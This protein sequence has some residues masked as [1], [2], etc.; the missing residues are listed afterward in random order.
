MAGE[1]LLSGERDTEDIVFGTLTR[2]A[3]QKMNARI[4]VER[5]AKIEPWYLE[6]F[7]FNRSLI[8]KVAHAI[9]DFNP[10]YLD[11]EYARQ[12]PFGTII[13]PPGVLMW[14]EQTNA[15][16]DGFPGLHALWREVT[17]EWKLPVKLGDTFTGK[18]VL[19][20]VA[21]VESELSGVAATQDYINI[22]TNQDGEEIGQVHTS[23]H[24][25]ERPTS[26]ARGKKKKK[27]ELARYR[28]ED[29][30][31]I[32]QDYQKEIRRGSTP[33][34]W[35]EVEAGEEIPFVV[36]GPTSRAQ[37]ALGE[38]RHGMLSFG[39]SKDWS[40][41]HAQAYKLFRRY[42]ALRVYL[43][44]GIPQVPLAIHN[45]TFR[46]RKYL[47]LPG[48]Y[49]AGYQRIDWTIHMLTNWQGDHGFLKKLYLMFTAPNL[50]G[51]TTWCRGR[52]TGKRIEGE[53]HIV[54]IE[55]DN[56]NQM[57]VI[58]SKGSAEVVLM[59]KDA[60]KARKA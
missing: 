56:I 27:R 48:G 59:S 24:R 43:E 29:I 38:T 19:T 2:G 45:S 1:E 31:K 12:S 57:D 34:F 60:R 9:G 49:D 18:T 50:M 39:G 51:D 5:V 53:Q 46:S 26:A 47:G 28:P 23:W 58:V 54:D 22:A 44:Q 14:V 3:V 33:R 41:S 6:E 10:L 25:F 36:K 42:P 35:E 32:R 17:L 7:R 20:D 52:V 16:T 4:G 13:A 21:V 55:L 8:R 11:L 40:V 37:R 15:A 30:E